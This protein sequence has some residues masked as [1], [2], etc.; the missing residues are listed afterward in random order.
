MDSVHSTTRR[1]GAPPAGQRLTRET[2]LIRAAAL[3]ARDGLTSFSLRRLAAELGVTPNAVYN[4]VTGRD[5]LLD[6]VTER[7]VAGMHLPAGEQ[8]WPDWVHAAAAG[9]RAQL[10]EHPGL[11]DLVL[12]RAGATT[13]GPRLLGAF[14]DQLEAA[15]L[16][17]AM[18]HLA[19]HAVLTV[20]VGSLTHSRTRD[21]DPSFDAV[22][23]VTIAGLSTAA[24][25][26]PTPRAI[27]L[28]EAHRLAH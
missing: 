28:L 26:P 11:T 27:A 25:Q 17:R 5:D 18:A 2:V 20:V 23:D 7:V 13:A 3:I 22:L 15:G 10:A 9:L 14:L 12:S 4:H 8:T 1:R 24:R 19:W 21:A 16:D 6:A